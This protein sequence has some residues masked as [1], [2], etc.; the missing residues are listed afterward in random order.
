MT[1]RYAIY[2][3]PPPDTELAKFGISWLGWNIDRAERK[4]IELL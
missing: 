3:V 2:F 1:A 4:K